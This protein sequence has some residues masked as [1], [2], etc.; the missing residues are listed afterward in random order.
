MAAGSLIEQLRV[1]EKSSRQAPKTLRM[2]IGHSGLQPSFNLWKNPSIRSFASLLLERRGR[3]ALLNQSAL[4]IKH[5][6]QK[7]IVCLDHGVV[8][9][10]PGVVGHSEAFH[11]GL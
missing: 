2:G 3:E 4:S 9:I 10:I 5:V 11:Q 7:W 8:E 1:V 6:P